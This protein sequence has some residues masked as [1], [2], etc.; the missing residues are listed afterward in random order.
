MSMK[1]KIPDTEDQIKS[2]FRFLKKLGTGAFGEIYH[3]I[4]Q[5]NG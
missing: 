5:T 2:R 3:A 1:P 4:D